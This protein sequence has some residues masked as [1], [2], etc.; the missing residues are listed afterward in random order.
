MTTLILGPM[1]SGKTTELIRRCKRW[2]SVGKKVL[3]INHASDTRRGTSDVV[4]H[5][6]VRM[7]SLSL[8]NITTFDI[9]KDYDVIA[10]DEAQFFTGLDKYI[11]KLSDYSGR[12]VI[13][14]ALSGDYRREPW[15]GIDKLIALSDDIVH[16]KAL[17]TRCNQP[18]PFT[19]KLG[20]SGD[21]ID[22][23]AEDKYTSLCRGCYVLLK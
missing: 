3:I 16:C 11:S 6:G 13:I 21:R 2:Q 8:A 5:D 1:F 9:F 15:P 4:T 17:C 14:S 19:K 22:I 12:R 7:S 20:D 18:A 23:G 10:F